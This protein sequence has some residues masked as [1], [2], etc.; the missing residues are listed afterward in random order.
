MIGIQSN[1]DALILCLIIIGSFMMKLEKVDAGASMSGMLIHDDNDAL[2]PWRDFE[3]SYNILFATEGPAQT[4]GATRDFIQLTMQQIPSY[5]RN[6]GLTK[7]DID[8]RKGTSKLVSLMNQIPE[9]GNGKKECKLQELSQR[10]VFETIFAPNVHVNSFLKYYNA[11]YYNFCINDIDREII[12][13]TAKKGLD[14]PDKFDDMKTSQSQAAKD[15]PQANPYSQIARGLILYL[16][17]NK[18]NV[19]RSGDKP[20]LH[21]KRINKLINEEIVKSFK[22]EDL[23]DFELVL[24]KYRL[25]SNLK[26]ELSD[27]SRKWI[28]VIDL[29]DKVYNLSKQFALIDLY[30]IEAARLSTIIF[31][32]A[33]NPEFQ[34]HNP[35]NVEDDLKLIIDVLNAKKRLYRED[36]RLSVSKLEEVKFTLGD[37][38]ELCTLINVQKLQSLLNEYAGYPNVSNYLLHK[39]KMITKKCK[40]KFHAEI[41]EKSSKLYE[42]DVK[43]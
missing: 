23:Q 27:D 26:G 19:E 36:H 39:A 11:L 8:L 18:H 32:P 22:C 24:Q 20:T 7:N 29:C 3:N 21:L 41:L 9:I 13:V 1:K 25:V 4:P 42:D 14:L 6:T 34:H 35:E 38:G 12:K 33:N 10:I 2:A 31:M 30:E 37:V 15:L 5:T 17:S 40:D 16:K 28:D 43:N